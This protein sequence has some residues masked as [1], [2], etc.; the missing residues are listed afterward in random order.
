MVSSISGVGVAHLTLLRALGC[1]HACRQLGLHAVVNQTRA[2][3]RRQ[4]RGLA[5]G[6]GSVDTARVWRRRMCHSQW[7]LARTCSKVLV[8]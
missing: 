2:R 3:T 8:G 6:R 5:R 4:A 1:I 7:R